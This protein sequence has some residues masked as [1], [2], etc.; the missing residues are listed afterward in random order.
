M[1]YFGG[2]FSIVDRRNKNG[3]C[4]IDK[5]PIGSRHYICIVYIWVGCIVVFI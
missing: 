5:P 4:N 1:L 2:F 3:V